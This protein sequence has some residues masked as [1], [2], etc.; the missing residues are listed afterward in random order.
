[1]S[2]ALPVAIPA[3]ALLDGLIHLALV[4]MFRRPGAPFSP[5]SYASGRFIANFLAYTV[6]AF[7]FLLVQNRASVWAKVVDALLI[8]LALATLV[9]W[10]A[11]GFFPNPFGFLGYL[12]KLIEIVL[13]VLVAMHLWGLTRGGAPPQTAS[14]RR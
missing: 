6:L 13:I 7:A 12:S 1:M 8:L 14:A 5:F 11:T 4:F 2:R 9:A 10:L 3:L